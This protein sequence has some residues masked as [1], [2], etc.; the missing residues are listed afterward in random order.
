MTIIA[1]MGIKIAFSKNPPA[2]T[3][4]GNLKS[5]HLFPLYFKGNSRGTPDTVIMS[6]KMCIIQ[7]KETTAPTHL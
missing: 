7:P 6:P 5:H 1:K 2:F 4:K 3:P